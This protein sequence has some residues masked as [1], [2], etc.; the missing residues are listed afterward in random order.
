M[1]PGPASPDAY[2]ASLDEPR[3]S[4]LAQLHALIRKTLPELKP[5]MHSGMV[6]Y[7]R[8]H[9]RYASGREGDSFKVGLSSRKAAISLYVA[10]IDKGGYLAEQA[11]S[12][13]G[14]VKVGK[15]CIGFRSL[16]DLDL[17]ALTKLLKRVK[18]AKGAGE[19]TSGA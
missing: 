9:Y 11:A 6:G 5:F 19:V 3:R 8:Y 10:V 1:K 18:R 4:E 2:F 13:L 17:P 7:G 15:S 16:A 14:K 12:G